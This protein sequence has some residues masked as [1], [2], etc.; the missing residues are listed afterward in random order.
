LVA[1]FVSVASGYAATVSSPKLL[2]VSG[3]GFSIV[4]KTSSGKAVK[5][6][7]AG[8]YAIKVEDK[9]SIHNFHLFGPGV[10]KATSVPFTGTKTWTV[11]LKPG[12]YTF[13]CDVHAASGMKGVVKVTK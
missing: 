12:T 3:P 10:N 1:V 11:K 9:S 7:K 8:T 5:N 13:Q 2:G 4:L 6:L